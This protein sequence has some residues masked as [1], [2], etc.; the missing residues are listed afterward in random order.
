MAEIVDNHNARASDPSL[1]SGTAALHPPFGGKHRAGQAAYHGQANGGPHFYPTANGPAPPG[2]PGSLHMHTFGDAELGSYDAEHVAQQ[3]GF[4][5]AYLHHQ[6]HHDHPTYPS[7]PSP[8][9]AREVSQSGSGAP[10]ASQAGSNYQGPPRL[11]SFAEWPE[12]PVTHTSVGAPA[13]PRGHVAPD[14]AAQ[15]L[16]D[17]RVHQNGHVIHPHGAH[18]LAH[19]PAGKQW[20]CRSAPYNA[21]QLSAALCANLVSNG[22]LLFVVCSTGFAMWPGH[23]KGHHSAPPEP[24]RGSHNQCG[25]VPFSLPPLKGLAQVQGYLLP[26]GGAAGPHTKGQ[27]RVSLRAGQDL[28]SPTRVMKSSASFTQ[29][30]GSPTRYDPHR[31]AAIQASATRAVVKTC[32]IPNTITWAGTDSPQQS[33]QQ[34]RRAPRAAPAAESVR[35]SFPP[36][37]RPQPPQVKSVF[38]SMDLGG[39]QKSSYSLPA[40]NSPGRSTGKSSQRPAM[41]HPDQHTYQEFNHKLPA[42]QSGH[43]SDGH[44]RILCPGKHETGQWTPFKA[45]AVTGRPLYPGTSE[46][47]VLF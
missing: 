32:V 6:P 23:A 2:A 13:V 36:M 43:P 30:A 27:P 10:R 26:S 17:S 12:P 4:P 1:P 33:P 41:Q 18:P 29:K 22:M 9:M 47:P 37:Q 34:R 20:H 21:A 42:V 14:M 7:G 46:P 15:G 8:E 5:G 11:H 40:L 25:P 19:G 16:G 38:I 28:I 24:H 31:I 3:P 39:V 45:H 35:H 44:G